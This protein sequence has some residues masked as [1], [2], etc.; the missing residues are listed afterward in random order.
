MANLWR[1]IRQVHCLVQTAYGIRANIRSWTRC[2]R[3]SSETA[4]YIK[5]GT[6]HYWQLAYDVLKGSHVKSLPP[7]KKTSSIESSIKE[8]S[9]IDELCKAI[10]SDLPVS[11][12]MKPTVAMWA[13]FAHLRAMLECKLSQDGPGD[14][15]K[16]EDDGFCAS[17]DAALCGTLKSDNGVKN[18]HESESSMLLDD[19]KEYGQPLSS[20]NLGARTRR[21]RGDV[22]KD[23]R[24]LEERLH[25]VGMGML[26]GNTVSGQ[27]DVGEATTGE[28]RAEDVCTD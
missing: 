28:E 1:L 19:F 12:R 27:G 22:S 26:R 9:N 15:G 23:Q 4:F 13:R 8:K 25:R 17:V 3:A 11:T 10:L 7:R 16:K 2:L 14:N 18:L 6:V 5:Y 21:D 24:I 20:L